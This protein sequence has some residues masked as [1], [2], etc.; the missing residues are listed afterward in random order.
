MEYFYIFS[1]KSIPNHFFIQFKKLFCHYKLVIRLLWAKY[2]V[3]L[4]PVIIPRLLWVLTPCLFPFPSCC[5]WYIET[6]WGRSGSSQS[7]AAIPSCLSPLQT[8]AVRVPALI[9]SER[10]M[11]PE[12]D[13][14]RWCFFCCQSLIHLLIHHSRIQ[15]MFNVPLQWM[16]W[17]G[18]NGEQNT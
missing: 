10:M 17:W 6:S 16:R 3:F 11:M 9:C 4:A 12:N 14:E 13:H 15:Q 2:K 5:F 7:R 8:Q 1:L 18:A